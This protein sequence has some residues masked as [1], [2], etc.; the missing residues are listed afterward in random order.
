M[1]QTITQNKR[2]MGI[3]GHLCMGDSTLASC[4][5]GYNTPTPG[6]MKFTTLIDLY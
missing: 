4:Q 6:V 5:K 2:S 1:N 3:D